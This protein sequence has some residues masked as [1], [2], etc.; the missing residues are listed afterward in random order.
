MTNTR[1]VVSGQTYPISNIASIRAL[2]ISPSILK[3]LLFMG[4]MGFGAYLQIKEGQFRFDSVHIFALLS[5]L[6]IGLGWMYAKR[7]KYVIELSSSSGQ[8]EVLTSTDARFIGRIIEAVNA[9][10]I[11]RG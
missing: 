3:P 4:V 5:V 6:L 10:I 8:R 9:A 7:T 1:F 11:A 2:S